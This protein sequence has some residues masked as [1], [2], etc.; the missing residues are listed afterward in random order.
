MADFSLNVT[1]PL[2]AEYLLNLGA[3][4]LTASYDLNREQLLDL[5]AAIPNAPLEIVLHQHMPLFHMEHCVF[6]A[7]LSPGTNKTNCGRPCDTHQVRLR[8]RAGM[9]H[10]LVADVGCRN[11]L[12]NATPQSGAEAA[13]ALLR[14]GVRHFRV[15]LLATTPTADVGRHDR[16]LRAT[17]TRGSR[18]NKFGPS[19]AP[20]IGSASRAARSNSAAIRW[21]FYSALIMALRP[22]TL[23]LGTQNL[24]KLREFCAAGRLA[25]AGAIAR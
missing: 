19:C 5:V 25:R 7:V 3:E 23:V 9:E 4:R 13:N 1:N 11:T 21:L 6:C 17:A 12:F 15:E 24:D 8:D 22:A 16:A 10:P 2:T 20:P 18:A 14:E